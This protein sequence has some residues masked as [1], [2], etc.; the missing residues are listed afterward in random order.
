MLRSAARE[1]T[2]LRGLGAVG[3]EM[4][5]DRGAEGCN[6]ADGDNRRRADD[7]FR[8]KLRQFLKC[9]IDY[10]LPRGRH[11]MHGEGRGRCRKAALDQFR[12]DVRRFVTAM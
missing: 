1:R 10:T 8:N 6:G 9:G 11:P 3:Q 7:T 4:V 5:L 2:S 12:D